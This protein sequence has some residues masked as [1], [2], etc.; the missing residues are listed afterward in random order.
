MQQFEKFC[1]EFNTFR[2]ARICN[3]ARQRLFT[4]WACIR[5]NVSTCASVMGQ[6]QNCIL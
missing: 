1:L 4:L 6:S 2:Q 5:V 3:Q